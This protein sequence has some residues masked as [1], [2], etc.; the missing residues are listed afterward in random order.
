MGDEV[1]W[2]DPQSSAKSEPAFERQ[3]TEA[4]F[5]VLQKRTCEKDKGRH[6]HAKQ[7]AMTAHK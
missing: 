2:A 7:K 4:C 3:V 5:E 6:A 1:R